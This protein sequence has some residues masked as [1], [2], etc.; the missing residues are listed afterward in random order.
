MPGHEVLDPACGAKMFWFD[1]E[2]PHALFSDM[3]EE[4][5]VLCDGR[6]FVVK[7]DILADF[8]SLPYPDS[9]FNL[10]V[11]DPPH[12]NRAGPQSWMAKKYG[13]LKKDTWRQDIAA[14]FDE[15]WRVLRPGGTLIFK[16]NETQIKVQDVLACLSE[17]PLF[18]QTTTQNLKTHWLVFYK[19]EAVCPK[20]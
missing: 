18:G 11:F 19:L 12:L 9:S 6:A 17:R 7:P 4:D 16:W 20:A 2:C 8:R 5:A 10:V 1:K 13:K 3:R 14:G 15:S